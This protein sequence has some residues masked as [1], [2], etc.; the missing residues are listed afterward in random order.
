MDPT[1]HIQT[2]WFPRK[3]HNSLDL[4]LTPFHESVL[5]LA[6]QN[7][8]LFKL[9]FLPSPKS[10]INAYL[11]FGPLVDCLPHCNELVNLNWSDYRSVDGLRHHQIY[12]NLVDLQ[13]AIITL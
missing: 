7:T 12:E 9:Y 1:F 2:L 4:T 3:Q 10:Y 5:L 8:A 13:N 6:Y 11:L